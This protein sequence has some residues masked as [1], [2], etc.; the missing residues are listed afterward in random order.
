M[1]ETERP[2]IEERGVVLDKVGLVKESVILENI[3]FRTSKEMLLDV[4]Y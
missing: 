2:R 3:Y 4:L 1:R